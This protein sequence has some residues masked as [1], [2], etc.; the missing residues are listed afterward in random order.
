MQNVST[1]TNELQRLLDIAGEYNQVFARVENLMHKYGYFVRVYADGAW[2]ITRLDSDEVLTKIDNLP[3]MITWL[4]LNTDRKPQYPSTSPYNYVA[5]F[6]YQGGEHAPVGV[7]YD[8]LEDAQGAVERKCADW[9]SDP[10]T[11]HLP[12]RGVVRNEYWMWHYDDGVWTLD[13][14]YEFDMSP[15]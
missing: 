7:G 12:C 6:S 1:L 3:D 4:V 8:V 13:A 5:L 9:L 11:K 15:E 10:T 2:T 14:S